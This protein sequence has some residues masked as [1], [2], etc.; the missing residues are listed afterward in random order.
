M[1]NKNQPILTDEIILGHDKEI[2][3]NYITGRI[4]ELKF[5]I[6][7]LGLRIEGLEKCFKNAGND[8]NRR[9]KC[10]KGL[11]NLKEYYKKIYIDMEE[12]K[13]E[14]IDKV[15]GELKASLNLFFKEFG[16]ND[17][18]ENKLSDAKKLLCKI[19]NAIEKELK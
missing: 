3:E 13:D 5:L 10:S 19:L 6:L 9:E 2:D 16:V 11:S 14:I 12:I 15:S 18:S 17:L 8:D 1:E 7:P 4:S